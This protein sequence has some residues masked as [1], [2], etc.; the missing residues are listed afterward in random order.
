MKVKVDIMYLAAL[1]AN[2]KAA[3]RIKLHDPPLKI[4]NHED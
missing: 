1:T 4:I 3:S 2:Q